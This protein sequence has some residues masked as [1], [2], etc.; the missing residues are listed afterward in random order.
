MRS[1]GNGGKPFRQADAGS[2]AALTV[3]FFK[4]HLG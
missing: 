1:R 2:G 4:Q 3:D